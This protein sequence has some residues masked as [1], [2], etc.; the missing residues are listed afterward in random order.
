MKAKVIVELWVEAPNLDE[1]RGYATRLTCLTRA[2]MKAQRKDAPR[3]VRWRHLATAPLDRIE[4]L[5]L[6]A[7]SRARSK[8]AREVF[9]GEEE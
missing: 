4:E 3:L 8:S 6:E 9:G 2:K 7:K 5:E 1:A